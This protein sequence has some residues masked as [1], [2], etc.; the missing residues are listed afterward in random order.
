MSSEDFRK[1]ASLILLKNEMTSDQSY[2]T[3]NTELGNQTDLVNFDL[4]KK[5]GKISK[6]LAGQVETIICTK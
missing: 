5:S 6:F 4:N 3:G 2:F 1:Q